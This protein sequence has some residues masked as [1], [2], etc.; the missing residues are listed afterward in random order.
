M[1]DH[2][3]QLKD[4]LKTYW[5]YTAFLV[6]T[7][8]FFLIKGITYTLIGSYVP[9]LVIAIILLLIGIGFGK[10]TKAFRRMI[11][12]WSILVILWALVRL[13][14]S[15][16]NLFVK[17]IPESHVNEQLGI[18]GIILSCTFLFAGFY[19]WRYRRVIYTD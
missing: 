13:L 12:L 3:I 11:S 10:S 4:Q 17:P 8:G 19:L 18:T 5:T 2:Q 6:A 15:M 16:V 7:L 14:L 9:L 1:K